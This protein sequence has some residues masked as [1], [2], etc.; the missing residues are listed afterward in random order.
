[1]NS[2]IKF[3]IAIR[4]VKIAERHLVNIFEK[5]II[6]LMKSHNIEYISYK[7]SGIGNCVVTYVYDYDYGGYFNLQSVSHKNGKLLLEFMD[8]DGDNFTT[9]I[10]E[11]MS[12]IDKSFDSTQKMHKFY[13][14]YEFFYT[15]LY[16]KIEAYING[17]NNPN[18]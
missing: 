11:L 2:K 13:I 3:K 14:D 12:S 5:E 4:E 18:E 6:S 1:M 15:T 17:L 16:D 10:D 9:T 7:D 8:D